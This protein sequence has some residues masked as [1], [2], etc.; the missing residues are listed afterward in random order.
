MERIPWMREEWILGLDLYFQYRTRRSTHD[1]PRLD[2]YSVFLR[3]LH[4]NTAPE[5]PSFRSAASIG[6]RLG[7]FCDCDPY[8]RDQGKRGLRGGVTKATKEI[9]NEFYD[10]DEETFEANRKALRE[11]ADE[12]KADLESIPESPN[13]NANGEQSTDDDTTAVQEG[14]I[15]KRVH[16]SRERKPQRDKKLRAFIKEHKKVFCEACGTEGERYDLSKPE[17]VFEVHHNI[18]L[19]KAAGI[20]ETKLDDLSVLCANCHRAI[21]AHDPVPSVDDFKKTLKG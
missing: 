5:N 13:E 3:K 18:P 14:R 1:N 8:W 7:N 15:Q 4:G 10:D 20:I 9:W 2:E 17:R 11:L 12:I 6:M 16:F 21:H 19:S